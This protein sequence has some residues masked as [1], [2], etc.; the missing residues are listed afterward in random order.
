[1]S[2]EITTTEGAV[3]IPEIWRPGFLKALMYKGKIRPR[4]LS[5]DG[6][7]KSMGDILHIRI[8][9]TGTT[10]N[11]TSTTGAITNQAL[12]PTEA[13][14]TVDK[15]KDY[16]F[17]IVDN[18]K[19]PA[20][21]YLEAALKES[22]PAAFAK[23]IDSDLFD[24]AASGLTT[25][26]AVDATSGLTGDHL[27]EAFYSLAV[28]EVDMEDPNNISWFFHWKQWPVLKKLAGISESQITGESGGG[29]LKFKVPD[30]L[31]VPVYFSSEVQL[32]TYHY[33]L[34]IHKEAFACG[35]QKNFN[36]EQLARVRKSTPYSADMMYGVKVVR[37][38]HGVCLT[39]TA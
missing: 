31:G 20:D 9:P 5:A 36:M 11:V 32:S 16:S 19:A 28:D 3:F 18:V 14:L 1:M 13:Q 24:L 23:A 6:D 30:V 35:V 29:L 4:V 2:N 22:A 10:N 25:Q 7:V 37:G 17:D 15:W 39:T 27:T 8:A 21:Q 12:T 33:N 38:T 34:L 26:T